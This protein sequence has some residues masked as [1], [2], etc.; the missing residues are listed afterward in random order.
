MPHGQEGRQAIVYRL[1]ADAGE[2]RALKVFKSRF[3]SA[4]LIPLTARIAAFADLLGLQ[5]CQR[6]I[7][8][9][10]HNAALI[11]Q[12]PD[13]EYAVLMPWVEGPT[14][15]EVML[16][17]NDTGAT[18]TAHDGALLALTLA[19][20]FGGME[21][22]GIAHCDL[23]ASNVILPALESSPHPQLSPIELVDVEQLYAPGLTQPNALPGGSDGYAHRT[24]ANGLWNANADRFAGAILLAEILGW[25][26]ERVRENAYGEQY[27]DPREMQNDCERYALLH[28]VLRENWGAVSADLFARAWHSSR[29]S[30]C[31]PLIEW[32]GAL[33]QIHVPAQNDNQV[34]L[35]HES[36]VDVESLINQSAEYERAG[37]LDQAVAEMKHALD[38]APRGSAL[39]QELAIALTELVNRQERMAQVYALA[40]EARWM[41]GQ[42]EWKR[43]TVLYEQ[44]INQAISAMQLVEWQ[45]AYAYCAEQ[46]GLADLFDQ[47][48]L[49]A[50]QNHLGAAEEL[51]TELVRR[52]PRY[53]RGGTQAATLLAQVIARREKNPSSFV[54]RALVFGTLAVGA[55]ALIALGGLMFFF[56]NSGPQPE[57]EQTN[58]KIA[59]SISL[60]PTPTHTSANTVATITP[61]NF[62][63]PAPSTIS[64]GR[65][66]SATPRS[67]TNPGISSTATLATTGSATWT[68]TST[69]TSTATQTSTPTATQTGTVSPTAWSPPPPPNPASPS[70]GTTL[71]QNTNVTLSWNVTSN[72]TQYKVEVWGGPYGGTTIVCDWQ[73]ATTCTLGQI[74]DGTVS[75]HVKA[76]NSNLQESNWSSTVSFTIQPFPSVPAL[77][78]PSN[79]TTYTQGATVTLIWNTASYATQY[80]VEVWGGPYNTYTTVCSWQSG[81]SCN[82]G[83]VGIGTVYWHVK[84]RNSTGESSWSETRSFTIQPVQISPPQLTSPSNGTSI[85]QGGSAIL[86]WYPSANATGYLVEV[87]GGPYGGY[88]TICNWQSN[89]SCDLGSLNSTG[90][91]YWHV[92]AR[93]SSGQES[94]WSSTWSITIQPLPTGNMAPGASRSP[95]GSGSGNA[96][97]GNLSTFWTSGLGHAFTLRLNFSRTNVNRVIVWDRPQNSPDNN[98]INALIISLSNGWSKRF[99]MDSMGRRCIDVTLVPFQM[100]DS[101]TLKADDAS[102]NN[103]LSEVEIWAGSKTYGPSCSNTGTMP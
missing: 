3:R 6:T 89:L 81:T 92:K 12:H 1:V 55:I 22:R 8:T 59:I 70:N 46:A 27:F 58:T 25:C 90:T 28:A 29:L 9:R 82:L 85:T 41:A 68:T 60:T 34:S 100:I 16:A 32:V 72:A 78:S 49:A 77:S 64:G 51:L 74:N 15:M 17:R 45:Q 35:P 44:L 24:A 96:F 63:T 103:G 102:G 56:L 57:D 13:L 101:V 26:D 36:V 18:F 23:S 98:Q 75:W 11:D 33:S 76:R 38:L 65:T 99:G 48:A 93:G 31:P 73:N 20:I 14:W 37:D 7:L 47:G 95:D 69:H 42:G 30:E 5:V 80:F 67:N 83:Q 43:A 54:P 2:Q 71:S 97:D 21:Q 66:P 53:A 4:A 91:F 61:T 87:W 39:K 79:G 84:A 19:R 88:T 10:Q 40:A 62:P 50:K 94:G 52:Q 86:T